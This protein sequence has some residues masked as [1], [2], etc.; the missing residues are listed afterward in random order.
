MIDTAT[1]ALA[2][3]VLAAARAARLRLGTAESCT[4][5][6]IAAALTD[7]A[8]ASDAFDLGLVTVFQ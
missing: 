6:M 7:P 5:G 1:F 4:G 2:Q 8:G 3:Q